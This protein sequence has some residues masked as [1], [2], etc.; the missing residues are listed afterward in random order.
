M[1]P[2]DYSSSLSTVNGEGMAQNKQTFWFHFSTIPT[3]CGPS[4]RPSALSASVDAKLA[5]VALLWNA[6][7]WSQ[8]R[9]A[10]KVNFSAF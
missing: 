7:H 10:R 8:N 5:E 2:I 6:W 4:N 3:D 1:T 9:P